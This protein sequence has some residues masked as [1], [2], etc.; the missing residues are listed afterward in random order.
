MRSLFFQSL[1]PLFP[2][3]PCADKLEHS[4]LWEPQTLRPSLLFIHAL[5]SAKQH[6]RLCVVLGDQLNP[7]PTMVE[8]ILQPEPGVGKKV[9]DIGQSL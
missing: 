5:L 7:H 8:F 1:I 9:L 3:Y 2:S 6:N 4:R